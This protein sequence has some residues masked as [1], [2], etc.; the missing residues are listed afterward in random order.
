MN[1]EISVATVCDCRDIFFRAASR[2][3]SGFFFP[4]DGHRPPLQLQRLDSIDKMLFA[5]VEIVRVPIAHP[6]NSVTERIRH[7]MQKKR[8]F[9]HEARIGIEY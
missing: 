4:F 2:R 5:E 6:G 9:I 1:L 8:F 7:K 3:A